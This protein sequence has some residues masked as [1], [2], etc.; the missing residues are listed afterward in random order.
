[1][2]F[3]FSWNIIV[4]LHQKYVFL[5][6]L[7]DTGLFWHRYT[8]FGHTD[9]GELKFNL[10]LKDDRN[11]MSMKIVQ[12]SIPPHPL[13][14][15]TSKIPPPPWP[16]TSNFRRAPSLQMIVNPLNEN[17]FQGWLLYVIR[18]FLQVGFRFPYQPINLVWISFEDSLL[19]LLLRGFILL[20]V[21]LSENIKKCLLL[22]IIH[23]FSTHFAIN[24]FYLH[25]LKA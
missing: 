7:L 2:G 24:L 21:Q 20:C 18:S 11:M 23:I 8:D 17:S 14:P 15:S 9:L 25:N 12:F 13:C 4:C 16:W 19:Y 3:L 1:M 5:G 6:A 22:K 10:K